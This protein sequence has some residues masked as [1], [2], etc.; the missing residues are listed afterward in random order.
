MD[1]TNAI[2]EDSLEVNIPKEV[3]TI[4]KALE[5]SQGAMLEMKLP[6]LLG[7]ASDG[8]QFV[9]LQDAPHMMVSGGTKGERDAFLKQAILSLHAAKGPGEVYF[10]LF[11]GQMREWQSLD[12]ASGVYCDAGSIAAGMDKLVSI[13]NNRYKKLRDILAERRG[14][15]YLEAYK[16]SVPFIV[17]LIDGINKGIGKNVLKLSATGRGVRIHM[18]LS[19]QSTANKR[20]IGCLKANFPAW[21]VFRTETS[22]ESKILLCRE[23][24]ECLNGDGDMIFEDFWGTQRI[25]MCRDM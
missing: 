2:F 5:V 14:K 10:Y 17:A 3:C 8:I 11:G 1:R 9:D 7:E 25:Q 24:A 6:V 13:M 12:S 21:V 16:S 18:I 23:G 15:A 19:V 20:I 22:S 4:E